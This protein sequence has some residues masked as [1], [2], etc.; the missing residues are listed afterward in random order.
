MALYIAW[1]ERSTPNNKT[2]ALSEKISN[3]NQSSDLIKFSWW[4]ENTGKP[5]FSHHNNMEPFLE[6]YG[7]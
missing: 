1:A 5:K 7:N 4:T 2:V 3:Q 6:K